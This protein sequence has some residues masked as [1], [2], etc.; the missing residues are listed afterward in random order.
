M[1]ITP[2]SPNTSFMQGINQLKSQDMTLQGQKLELDAAKQKQAD[3][4][5]ASTALQDYYKTGNQQ[6]LINATLKSPQLAGQMLTSLGLDDERKQKQAATDVAELWQLRSNPEEFRAAIAKKA[7]SYLMNRSNPS[8][9]INLGMAYDKDPKQAEMMLQ[10]VG[11]GL[12]ASG[13]KTGIFGNPQDNETPSS[14]KEFEYYQQLQKSNPEAAKQYAKAKGY[15]ESGREEN[16]TEAQRNLAEYQ[17]LQGDNPELAKQFGQAVGLVSKEGKELS[18]QAQKRLS[19]FTDAAIENQTLEQKYSTLASDFDK[20][21]V[22]GGVGTTWTEWA[23]EQTGNQDEISSLRKEF[24]K[25][26][27]SE[28]VK[29]LP[30]GAASDTDV[31]MAM[32]GFPSDKASGAQI[33]SFL[34]G[35]AKLKGIERGFNEF[36]ANYISENGTERGMLQ[37]W[38]ESQAKQ[39]AQPQ[40]RT[41]A[42]ILSQY[43]IN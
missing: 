21:N 40:N 25:I 6:S 7:D 41:E 23:K 34:R 42:D 2:F 14:Q 24:F 29:N 26:R 11:A 4:Q 15:I 9:I 28:V 20:A 33:A 10:S 16:R 22:G 18:A 12:E 5:E 27:G 32:A 31:A 17:R 43:G 1:A 35:L 19:E 3:L 37:A 38:K 39:P 30:A 36:K 8:N 13:F